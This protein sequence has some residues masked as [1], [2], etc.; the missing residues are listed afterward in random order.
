MAPRLRDDDHS[1][2]GRNHL[3]VLQLFSPIVFLRSLAQHFHD[4]PW[5]DDRV[6]VLAIRFDG[7]A[8][9][10][11]IWVRGEPGRYHA[12]AQVRAVD[13][14]F[15]SG[16]LIAERGRHGSTE[17]GVQRRPAGHRVNLTVE[18]L[19]FGRARLLEHTVLD[20]RVVVEADELRHRWESS[21]R[22]AGRP[23]KLRQMAQK[24]G[25]LGPPRER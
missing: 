16:E 12:H 2:E 25:L 11:H 17:G 10:G 21:T 15:R 18:E 13:A 9:D 4:D 24:E 6:P 19:V 8:H 22:E 3:V 7:P 23:L 14:G 1:L 5:V 20:V